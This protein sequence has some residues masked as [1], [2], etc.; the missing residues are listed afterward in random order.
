M[1][2]KISGK[3]LAIVIV[4]FAASNAFAWNPGY[5]CTSNDAKKE[6]LS[7]ALLDSEIVRAREVASG[8][9]R[10][11]RVTDSTDEMIEGV[12]LGHKS[13]ATARLTVI[14]KGTMT[15]K[16]MQLDSATITASTRVGKTTPRTYSCG[17]GK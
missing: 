10:Y 2:L 17:V 11:Y 6:K 7:V 4:S 3:G 14:P 16:L 5:E 15:F 8:L 13:G 1:S 12:I 9:D